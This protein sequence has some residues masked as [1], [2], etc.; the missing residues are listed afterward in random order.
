MNS[1][2]Q[3]IA[4]LSPE[5]RR[6]LYRLLREESV[7][8]PQQR[9]LPRPRGSR[10]APLSYAQ[11]RFWF[12]DQ[13]SPGSAVCNLFMPVRLNGEL[14]VPLLEQSF[15]EMV[16]RHE[17]LRTTFPCRSGQPVQVIADPP[18]D[19]RLPF[20]D[21]RGM[22]QAKADAES[23]RAA[24]Q[25]LEICFDLARGPLWQACLLR[26]GEREHVLLLALHHIIAD[27]VSLG[28]FKHEFARCYVAFGEGRQADLADLP[29]QYADFALWQHQSLQTG[30]QVSY[31]NRQLDGAPTVLELPTDRPRGAV[32]T[33]RGGRER[34]ALAESL[35]HSVKALAHRERA[36]LFM[37]LL[38]VFQTLLH[39]YSRQED[40]LV[41]VS[42]A[43]RN[44]AETERLIGCFV[45]A[46]VLR[47]RFTGDPT[48]RALLA[49]VREVVLDAHAHQDVPV[50]R[51]VEE[52]R[53][54]RD[55]SRN[56]LFQVMFVLQNSA[57]GRLEVPGLTVAPLEVKTVATKC[58]LTLSM[59]EAGTRLTAALEYNTDLFDAATV[60]GMLSHFSTLLRAVTEEPDTRVSAL[61]EQLA[62]AD[63]E[64]AIRQQKELHE[65]RLQKFRKVTAKTAKE[66][67][68]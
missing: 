43:G 4:A 25:L 38:A 48:F 10:E 9:I 26:L 20:V 2:A 13:W 35:V 63:E 51:I 15:R 16:R 44:R 36:T 59:E 33:F 50:Q 31:W 66:A 42:V 46:L 23:R 52:L 37:V 27:G 30:A 60:R 1:F 12:L 8:V 22:P 58:D 11:Q 41:G 61:V 54:D 28:I 49:R 32:R 17:V 5:R 3:Q 18:S 56:P 7:D 67:R 55:A 21:L 14:Q 39:R 62:R 24:V 65:M 53:L 57:P 68:V 19:Y 47:T 45:N 29:V 40:I 34:M 64:D 6:L